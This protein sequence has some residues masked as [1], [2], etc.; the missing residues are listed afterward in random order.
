MR[1]ARGL[2]E[3]Q[4]PVGV[5]RRYRDLEELRAESEIV[6]DHV[7]PYPGSRRVP[8]AET[9]WTSIRRTAAGVTSSHL[10]TPRSR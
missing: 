10:A 3:S 8:A 2:S 7:T 9:C 6:V 4:F 5:D 1:D